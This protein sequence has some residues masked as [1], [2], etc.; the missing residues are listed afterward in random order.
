M[1]DIRYSKSAEE[2]ERFDTQGVRDAFLVQNLFRDQT[3]RWTYVQ[4]DRMLIGG[5]TP[6]ARVP[7]TA[8]ASLIGEGNLLERR[9]LGVFNFGGP[10]LIEVGSQRFPIESTDMLYVGRTSDRLFVSSTDPKNPAR[11]YLVST[12]AHRDCPIRLVRAAEAE[13]LELGAPETCNRRTLRKFIFPGGAESCQLVMGFTTLHQGS[14]WNTMP[15]HTHLR[16][17]ETYLYFNIADDAVVFHFMGRPDNTRH[18]VV[19]NE[20]AIISPPWSIHCGAGTAAYS[21]VWAM[22]GEN[23]EFTDMDHVPMSQLA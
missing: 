4:D 20:E 19:R 10:G 22:A 7:L 21:F 2:S 3:V 8:D 6:A 18:L 1:T 13:T 15:C 11:L 9:E 17:M 14:A 5:C 16:R 23:Q 12:P